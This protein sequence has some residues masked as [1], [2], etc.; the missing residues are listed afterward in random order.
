MPEI[1]A[2]RPEIARW[3]AGSE[4][5]ALRRLNKAFEAF[6]GR[7]KAG[8]EPGYPRFKPAYRF[9]CVEWPSRGDACTWQ[10][11]ASRVYLQG[12]GHVKPSVHRRVEGKLKTISVKREA[13][14]WFLVL[15]CDEVP[16]K[17][18]LSTGSALGIDVGIASFLTTSVAQHIA[19]PRHG[20]RM[21][22]RLAT[23]QQ[24]LARQKRGSK[25]R[26]AARQVVA[27][28]SGL[29]R[30]TTNAGWGQFLSILKGKAEEA[31]RVVIDVNPRHTSQTCAECRRVDPGNRVS[32]AVFRCLACGHQAH[33][34][35]NAARNILRAGLARPAALAA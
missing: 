1:R 35:I 15:S 2:F 25:N 27:A 16:E 33:T 5:A 28:K 18:L 6:F 3:G 10:P 23:A 12:V 20:P 34:D 24:V 22:A 19:N 17:L 26:G 9:D 8:E 13:K 30:C 4:Q 21:A 7:V 31:G 29:N 32:Q 14:R 11:E